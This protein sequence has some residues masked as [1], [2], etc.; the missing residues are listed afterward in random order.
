MMCHIFIRVAVVTIAMQWFLPKLMQSLC[1]IS[2]RFAVTAQAPLPSP[3]IPMRIIR[4]S[5]QLRGALTVLQ[6][7]PIGV[8]DALT[9]RLLRYPVVVGDA[10]T[11]KLMLL[12][13]WYPVVI[14]DGALTM[15]LLLLRSPV[16]ISR[17]ALTLRLIRPSNEC[18]RPR[19]CQ[20]DLIIWCRRRCLVRQLWSVPLIGRMTRILVLPSNY[21]RP[22]RRKVVLQVIPVS[23][24]SASI[25][26]YCWSLQIGVKRNFGLI[27]LI[28]GVAV[29][30]ASGGGNRHG[31]LDAI[32]PQER[33]EHQVLVINLEG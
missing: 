2:F 19:R 12:L 29:D 9:V 27:T 11:M 6:W 18:Y 8:G 26:G 21:A 16:V 10:L 7:S 33:D 31:S 30:T 17:D 1:P 22:L 5:L 15:R 3:T 25:A 14:V 24:V 28:I 23:S 13:L 20:R 4:S 32:R